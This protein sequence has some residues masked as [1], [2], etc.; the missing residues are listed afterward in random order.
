MR[1]SVHF[2][3]TGALSGFECTAKV[4]SRRLRSR[5]VVQCAPPYV[6]KCPV[7]VNEDLEAPPE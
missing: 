1:C 3:K 5:A 2:E 4:N 6:L 7:G